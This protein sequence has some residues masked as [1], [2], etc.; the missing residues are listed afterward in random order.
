MYSD[1]GGRRGA[2]VLPLYTLTFGL[3]TT[4]CATTVCAT[5]CE[6]LGRVVRHRS[7][8]AGT[9]VSAASRALFVEVLGRLDGMCGELEDLCVG[10][11][12][13]DERVEGL[14]VW[15]AMLEESEASVARAR[16]SRRRW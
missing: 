7:G 8:A 13:S 3:S 15:V 1:G 12:W 2:A 4:V 11:A 6:R 14:S 9:P 10:K 5:G 16:R